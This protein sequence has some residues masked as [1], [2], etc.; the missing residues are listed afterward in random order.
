MKTKRTLLLLAVFVMLTFCITGCGAGTGKKI[1]AGTY[2]G[3]TGKTTF[4]FN[5]DGTCHYEE[6]ISYNGKTITCDGTWSATDDDTFEIVLDGVGTVLCGRYL[7]SG[8]LSVT[9]EGDGWED[10]IFT[11]E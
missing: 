11:K 3:S 2:S 9:A 10:E 7:Q 5:A 1:E 4:V 8:G 6:Y